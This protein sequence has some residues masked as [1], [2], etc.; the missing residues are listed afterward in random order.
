MLRA[1]RGLGL[2]AVS[3]LNPAFAETI[4]VLYAGSLVNL[5]E[6][7][8]LRSTKLRATSSRDLPADQMV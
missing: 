1:E 5:M 6:H 2:L 7:G 8:V 3:I 4:V